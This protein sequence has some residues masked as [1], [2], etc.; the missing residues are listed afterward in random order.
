MSVLPEDLSRFPITSK[1]DKPL[2][3]DLHG[4][5]WPRQVSILLPSGAE[6]IIL[7]VIPREQ[8]IAV[9]LCDRAVGS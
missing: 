4:V 6:A 5:Y 2:C 9:R 1:K 3:N 8:E 7:V